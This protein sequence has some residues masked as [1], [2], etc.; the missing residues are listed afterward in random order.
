MN[1]KD[2]AQGLFE[3][4]GKL[5]LSVTDIS[6]LT[7]LSK[8]TCGRMMRGVEPVTGKNTGTRYWYEDVAQA[9]TGRR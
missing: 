5:F 9:I 1:D 6:R 4:A 2:L 7:G 3:K 8:S